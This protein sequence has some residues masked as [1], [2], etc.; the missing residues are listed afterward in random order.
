MPRS[1]RGKTGL[2]ED[3]YFL[4]GILIQKLVSDLPQSSGQISAEL[5]R[6]RT[7][8]KSALGFGTG[9]SETAVHPLG[10]IRGRVYRLGDGL[11]R[12][13]MTSLGVI[14]TQPGYSAEFRYQVLVPLYLAVH[15]KLG[16]NPNDDRVISLPPD[17]WL[18]N[19]GAKGQ[20]ALLLPQM[21]QTVWQKADG[22]LGQPTQEYVPA[23]VLTQTE[24]RL[25]AWLNLP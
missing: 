13:L 5:L 14:L 4:P 22:D 9:S 7:A 18:N 19:I 10:A 3:T 1:M 24:Q 17:D 20:G 11:A 12:S 6:I 15:T 8:M 21:V 25:S 23:S 16:V 2:V